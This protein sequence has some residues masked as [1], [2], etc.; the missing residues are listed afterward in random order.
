MPLPLLALAQMA[1]AIIGGVSRGIQCATDPYRRYNNQ[2]IRDLKDKVKSGVGLTDEEKSA[3]SN[4]AMQPARAAMGQVAMEQARLQAAS[5]GVGGG[6][7]QAAIARQQSTGIGQAATQVGSELARQDIA[8]KAAYKQELE[9]RLANKAA[10]RNDFW[11][12]EGQ[13][14]GSALQAAGARQGMVD[15]GALSSKA[16]VPFASAIN[17]GRGVMRASQGRSIQGL[18]TNAMN[19]LPEAGNGGSA[20]AGNAVAAAR[21][22]APA[23]APA[24]PTLA[25]F[26]AAQAGM[27]GASNLAGAAQAQASGVPDQMAAYARLRPDQQAMFQ[28]MLKA[29]IPAEQ[30]LRMVARMGPDGRPV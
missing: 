24:A 17:A 16:G 8:Q 7:Q 15:V 20:N 27:A 26:P 2:Q 28:E 3:Y 22:A 1:P 23:M 19:A 6:A 25:S 4:V 9:D 18:D 14:V 30:A 12:D 5:G 29:N 13:T 21:T 10:T 11:R